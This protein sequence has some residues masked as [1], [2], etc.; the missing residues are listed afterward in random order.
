MGERS[1]KRN[2]I[3]R[4]IKGIQNYE[5]SYI[6]GNTPGTTTVRGMPPLML[7]LGIAALYL[8]P[9]LYGCGTLVIKERTNIKDT[10][11]I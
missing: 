9:S 3:E 10:R 11:E 5:N 1:Q 4:N 8:K 7:T 2:W 6:Q